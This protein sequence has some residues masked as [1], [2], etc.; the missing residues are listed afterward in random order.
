MRSLFAA[1]AFLFAALPVAAQPAEMEDEVLGT[2]AFDEALG[3][4]P[5]FV[6]PID[7]MIDGA[8][9]AYLG[10]ALGDAED[11]D[12]ALVVLHVDT[13]GGLVD[14]ADEMRKVLLDAPTPTVAF[15]DKNAAS[16][17]ALISYAA[18]KIVMVPGAA[19][20]AATAVD[21]QGAY[22]SE[23]IQSYMRSLMRS[24]AEANGRD[25]AI[26]E[27]MVDEKLA[28]DGVVE[29]G[30]LLTL[31]ADEALA[32]G[33]A[34]AVEP[35]LG[36]LYAD[37]GVTNNPRVEHKASTPER[38]LRF[39]ASPVVASLLM[40]MMMGG[41]YFELQ[42]PG[43]GFAGS[44][45]AIGAAAFFAPH[46]L[47]GLVESWEIVLFGIG[48]LLIA[49]E[50]FVIPGFGLAGIGG[51]TLTLVALGAALLPNVGFDF[52]GTE[53]LA[54]ALGTLAMAMV[55]TVL[56]GFSLS[57]RLPQNNRFQRL[58]LGDELGAA[59]GYTSAATDSALLGLRGRALTPLRPAGVAEIAA[60]TGARRVDVVSQGTFVAAGAEV[61]VVGV[62]G[63]GVE[64][65][66]V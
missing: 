39:L 53:G 25:G 54:R 20:G 62:R 8:L 27:A 58:V 43:V 2:L 46:Y 9:A 6:V 35:D 18:D 14:A 11:A 5:V 31:T 37:L 30:Q 45:A 23:K 65:R 22:A 28:I 21:G 32:L 29:A 3:D 55:L 59:T 49:A 61:E 15:I 63:S 41:L 57:K 51:I 50:I 16:A 13:F 52:P 40:M 42:T 12:A 48:L 47:L 19:I 4:G 56:L 64:V 66:E 38:V 26:A 36:G 17:G 24:T 33:V 7:G 10:R 1:L 60:D 34:D 44:I